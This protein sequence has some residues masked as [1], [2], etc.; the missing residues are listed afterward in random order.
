M[1]DIA[2]L[3]IGVSFTFGWARDLVGMD[4]CLVGVGREILLSLVR[5]GW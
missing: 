5:L 3:D 1:E 2:G 4:I